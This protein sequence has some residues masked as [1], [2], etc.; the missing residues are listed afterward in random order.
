MAAVSPDQFVFNAELDAVVVSAVAV[1]RFPMSEC[2]V[3]EPALRISGIELMKA[4]R[5]SGESK[6]GRIRGVLL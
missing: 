6:K 4:L 3:G 5:T 2:P 1:A